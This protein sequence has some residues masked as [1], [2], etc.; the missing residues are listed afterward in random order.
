MEDDKQNDSSDDKQTVFDIYGERIRK[1]R[2][3]SSPARIVFYIF[4]LILMILLILWVR[5]RAG[6]F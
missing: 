6:M 3:K 2:Q 4:A 1:R 5:G